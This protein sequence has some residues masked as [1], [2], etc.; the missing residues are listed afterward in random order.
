MLISKKF[1]SLIQYILRI[2]GIQ[3]MGLHIPSTHTNVGTAIARM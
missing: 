2:W 1:D 3:I